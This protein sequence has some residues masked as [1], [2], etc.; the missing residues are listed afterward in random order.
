MNECCFHVLIK[1][2]TVILHAGFSLIWHCVDCLLQFSCLDRKQASHYPEQLPFFRLSGD[3]Q[4]D[5]EYEL[6]LVKAHQTSQ[7]RLWS[8]STG[9]FTDQIIQ[10]AHFL[11]SLYYPIILLNFLQIH[12][13]FMVL[14]FL[15]GLP[16]AE[17]L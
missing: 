17:V 13:Y 5:M 4:H 3:Y 1:L 9:R 6:S 16:E 7:K 12:L 8:I 2:M 14:K 10:F 15:C 11:L